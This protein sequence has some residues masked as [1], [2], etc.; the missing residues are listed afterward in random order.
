MPEMAWD[1]LSGAAKMVW[2]VLPGVT[3]TAWDVL[4]GVANRYGTFFQ[5]LEAIYT[6]DVSLKFL[7]I[8]YRVENPGKCWLTLHI[9]IKEMDKRVYQTFVF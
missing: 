6:G 1:V 7:Y 2:D 4:S 5:S 9:A 8:C 3:K